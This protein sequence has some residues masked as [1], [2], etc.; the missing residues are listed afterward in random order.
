MR[1]SFDRI[2][3]L[4]IALPDSYSCT[5]CG[6]SLIACARAACVIPF[7][8]LAVMMRFL[9]SEGTL[10]ERRGMGERGVMFV[11]S[12]VRE[13]ERE[14]NAR[15]GRKK[16][17]ERKKLHSYRSCAS[18]S[19]SLSSLAASFSGPAPDLFVPAVNFLTVSTAAPDLSAALTALELV[20]SLVV[21]RFL[22]RMIGFQSW[23]CMVFRFDLL[24]VC[25]SV[26]SGLFEWVGA[27][28]EGR[29]H[30]EREVS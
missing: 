5:I 14:K 12:C 10:R 29:V 4:G 17:K 8:S 3:G 6:F 20:A 21:G 26:S 7:A 30:G 11:G 18:S 22:L 1:D 25:L 9:S 19:V 24:S 23:P 16:L 13:Q 2:A 27:V 15:Q 28:E